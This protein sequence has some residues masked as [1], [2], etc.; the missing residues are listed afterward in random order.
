MMFFSFV[1]KLSNLSWHFNFFFQTFFLNHFIIF[2]SLEKFSAK[3]TALSKH[4]QTFT[5]D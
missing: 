3:V 2:S 4:D 5:S 1:A